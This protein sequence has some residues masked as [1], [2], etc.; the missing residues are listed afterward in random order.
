MVGPENNPRAR[1]YRYLSATSE[2]CNRA[3]KL[4][5]VPL[6][7]H[8]IPDDQ[9]W[10]PASAETAA[11][12]E[13]L[14]SMVSAPHRVNQF[15]RGDIPVSLFSDIDPAMV[16]NP[17]MPINIAN[18][19]ELNA[20]Y[21]PVALWEFLSGTRDIATQCRCTHILLQGAGILLTMSYRW[22][23]SGRRVYR[24]QKPYIPVDATFWCWARLQT[25]LARED[26][27]C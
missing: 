16:L 1:I 23:G 5:V 15:V 26:G 8:A 21:D 13:W 6:T 2:Y 18:T 19:V 9:E 22:S 7:A 4:K 24:H 10:K 20:D 14:N 11:V 17:T 25:H 12:K 3:H 27:I